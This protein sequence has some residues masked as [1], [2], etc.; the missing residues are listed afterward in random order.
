VLGSDFELMEWL[1]NGGAF[2]AL[3]TLF[4]PF[5]HIGFDAITTGIA[6]HNQAGFA[7]V[8]F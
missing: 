2:V 5:N 4:T 7:I 8:G 3:S 1:K 6:T